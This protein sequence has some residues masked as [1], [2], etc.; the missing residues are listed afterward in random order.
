MGVGRG[1]RRGG[2]AEGSFSRTATPWAPRSG[3]GMA[4]E[5]ENVRRGQDKLIGEHTHIQH[6]RAQAGDCK[7]MHAR[8]HA[9]TRTRTHSH[10]PVLAVFQRMEAWGA[11]ISWRPASRAHKPVEKGHLNFF[12]LEFCVQAGSSSGLRLTWHATFISYR[13]QPLSSE[14]GT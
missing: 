8:A 12:D 1:S 9:R 14:L 13:K 10:T 4:E 2:G 3:H 7:N 11:D 6:G 5:R